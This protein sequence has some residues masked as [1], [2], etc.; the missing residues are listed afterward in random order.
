MLHYPGDELSWTSRAVYNEQDRRVL[1]SPTDIKVLAA[2]MIPSESPLEGFNSWTGL[3]LEAGG[4][5]EVQLS[6]GSAVTARSTPGAA[7]SQVE[8]VEVSPNRMSRGA[9][10][11]LLGL[12]AALV[13]GLLIGL[14][15]G[16]APAHTQGSEA[17]DQN[18]RR[19]SRLAD[20]YVSGEID[21]AHFEKE[22]DAILA[23]KSA[24]KRASAPRGHAGA[25]S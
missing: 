17:L 22:R 1:V 10:P 7:P 15:R 19:I 2:Q 12:S 14:S 8:R 11:I 3:P 6:G 18:R 16:T 4:V 13:L 20:R 24:K 9:V 25:R 5:W 21:R 23:A